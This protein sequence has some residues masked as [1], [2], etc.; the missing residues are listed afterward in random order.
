MFSSRACFSCLPFEYSFDFAK[1][2]VNAP[3]AIK[4]FAPKAIC[5]P[6]RR[7]I[8]AVPESG[9]VK[10]LNKATMSDISGV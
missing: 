4:S 6:V 9:I 1:D 8:K 2:F 3:S 5:G 10:L 7:R